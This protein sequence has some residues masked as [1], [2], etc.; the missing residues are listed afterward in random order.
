[1]RNADFL[2][3]KVQETNK[4]KFNN[5]RNGNQKVTDEKKRTLGIVIHSFLW[6]YQ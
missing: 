6:H 2:S 1:M 3:T 4:Q 5:K